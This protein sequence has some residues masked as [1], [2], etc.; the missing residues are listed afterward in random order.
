MRAGYWPKAAMTTV[1]S[2]AVIWSDL[3][4]KS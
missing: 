4:C 1:V 3:R 2:Q